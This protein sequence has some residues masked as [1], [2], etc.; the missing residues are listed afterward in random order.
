MAELGVLLAKA[1]DLDVDPT[2]WWVSEKLDGMRAIW[3]GRELLSLNGNP[4]PAPRWF[5]DKLPSDTKLDGELWTGRG[6]FQRLISIARSESVDK[7]WASVKLQ[8][9]DI[10][11]PRADVFEKRQNRLAQIVNTMRAQHVSL[12]RQIRCRD[13]QHL[14]ELMNEYVKMGAEGLMLRK[15]SSYYEPKR[16]S[17]L[18]KVKQFHD[19]D[20]TVTGYVDG[21]GKH[22][23][24]MGALSCKLPSG[25]TFEVG[26]GFTDAQREKPPRIG[27]KITF[28]YQELTK[29]GVPRFPSFVTAR[30][31]E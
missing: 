8:L 6:D 4:I 18:L 1:Y 5:V 29:D 2:G 27:T 25:V 26:T 14:K 15:P 3:T 13:A 21:K 22:K 19:A 31:Y 11:D 20:A 10:P 28:R 30:D 17:T 7:G 16:S 12:V 24:R 23:G 9:F